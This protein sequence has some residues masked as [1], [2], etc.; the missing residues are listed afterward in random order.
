[1]EA[2]PKMTKFQERTKHHAEK[3]DGNELRVL[4]Q[5]RETSLESGAENGGGH[6]HVKAIEEHS[7]PDE[8]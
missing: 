4:A 8:Q 1:M 3:S 6:V 7:N 2:K 5:S